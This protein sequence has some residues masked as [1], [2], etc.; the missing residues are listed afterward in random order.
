MY[1]HSHMHL[2]GQTNDRARK[3]SQ[4]HVRMI[5]HAFGKRMEGS[6]RW[7]RV[8]SSFISPAV[9]CRRCSRPF[10]FCVP[11]PVSCSSFPIPL[12]LV[13]GCW[14]LVVGR[15][16]FLSWQVWVCSLGSGVVVVKTCK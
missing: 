2:V 5:V 13:V 16:V 6:Q 12:S 11:V 9:V 15:W 7:F 3:N 8:V 10:I 1:D 14:H 4:M